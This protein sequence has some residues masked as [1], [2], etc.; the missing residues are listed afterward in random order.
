MSPDSG[1]DVG[2][3]GT[4]SRTDASRSVAPLRIPRPFVARRILA[5][6]LAW[7]SLA[8]G[9]PAA[10]RS[11]PT[12]REAL[13]RLE[14]IESEVL[15]VRPETPLQ[16]RSAN[17][18]FLLD[19][20]YQGSTNAY[21]ND[22]IR[23]VALRLLVVNL[24]AEDRTL[25]LKPVR[26]LSGEKRF[27]WSTRPPGIDGYSFRAGNDY[28]AIREV[29]T[30]ETLRLPANGTAATWMLFAGLERDALIPPMTLDIPTAGGPVALDVNLYQRGVL[31]LNSERV[32]PGKCLAVLTVSGEL[33][34]INAGALAE[35]L[36]RLVGQGVRRCVLHWS[37]VAPQPADLLRGWV[38][39][40]QHTGPYA[41]SPQYRYL[42]NFPSTL[43]ELHVAGLTSGGESEFADAHTHATLSGAI[44]AAL[45][46]VFA[47]A[48]AEEVVDS[49]R[50]GSAAVQVAALEHGAGRLTPQQLPLVLALAEGADLEV[51]R[52][53]L[54]ALAEFN[55]PR[56]HQM[57]ATVCRT[58]DA[59]LAAVAA[60][61]LA[62][63]RFPESHR[64]LADAL[65]PGVAIPPAV[66]I[67]LLT[68]YPRPEWQDEIYRLTSASDSKVR[69]AAIEALARLGH[70]RLLETL[71]GALQSDQ[72][73]VREAAFSQ[74]IAMGR[75][76]ADELALDFTL[77]HLDQA[78]P[79]GN[80]TLFLTRIRDQRAVPRLLTHLARSTANR[81]A[82]I[83][84][85]AQIGD[86]DVAAAIAERF[87]DYTDGEKALALD[88]LRKLDSPLGRGLALRALRSDDAN[89][90]QNALQTLQVDATDAEVA[91]LVEVV[92]SLPTR[93]HNPKLR[94]ICNG[95]G[96]MGT[97]AARDALLELRTA[98]D[99]PLREAAQKG[100]E[101]LWNQ[102][103]ARD[104]VN[105]M[106]L[107]LELAE[108][109]SLRIQ[110]L[111]TA[112]DGEP[113]PPELAQHRQLLREELREAERSIQLAQRLDPKYP[114]LYLARGLWQIIRGET[115]AAVEDLQ[116]AV[117]MNDEDA[118]AQR[119]LGDLW[120]RQDRF[121][122]ALRP[123]QRAG[124]LNPAYHE[125]ITSRAIALAR[126]GRVEEGI[127]LAREHLPR[128]RQQ[129]VYL[130]NVACVYGR[131]IEQFEQ[132]RQIPADD[133]RVAALADEAVKLLDESLRS[134]LQ[135][136]TGDTD[137][138]GY[139]RS[140]P[141]LTPLHRF[142][143]FRR[144]SELDLPDGERTAP[145]PRE[146][147]DDPEDLLK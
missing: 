9:A 100:L 59:E 96:G 107:K 27:D 71:A 143:E 38:L 49:L 8:V 110:S 53:A 64:A 126:L 137:M 75:R 73:R 58:G 57:L 28:V 15:R 14:A 44:S 94:L 25:D 97:P 55:D 139:M 3:I 6:A 43:H 61:S 37:P 129:S 84:L 81:D 62:A 144:I 13:E 56:A 93:P 128:H 18:V 89:L 31:R 88:A 46:S 85:L 36:D 69:Q 41:Y 52:A 136:A 138:L 80:M 117:S 118:D 112:L 40:A 70:P 127:A 65:Q 120:F 113:P 99:D 60:R 45:A 16:A 95:L 47:V 7:L 78:P 122:E 124:E 147:A 50:R 32:G 51:R 135:A 48:P 131:A 29:R 103:P 108:R 87:G 141:D 132:V 145:L 72:D 21:T 125:A 63:S 23:Y 134:G 2:G 68:T 54:A 146:P 11:L 77:R 111:Q 79:T 19:D 104:V 133:P 105:N 114:R 91:A 66:L 140:D 39:Q 24:T 17:V 86:Q 10:E 101:V 67:E 74:L 82:L 123:L 106:I 102:S 119:V 34:T 121:E 35:D 5:V 30:P 76:D 92:R 90:V 109:R 1:G 130:Y 22:G 142:S 98:A 116:L 33:N 4:T 115:S 26:L 83:Q 12:A 20:V 42:P